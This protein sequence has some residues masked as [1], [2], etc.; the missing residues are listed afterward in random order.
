[1]KTVLTLLTLLVCITSH[2]SHAAQPKPYSEVRLD[3]DGDGRDDLV[4][5]RRTGRISFQLEVFYTGGRTA[6][7]Y[8]KLV[9]QELPNPADDHHEVTIV[10][11]SATSFRI[12]DLFDGGHHMSGSDEIVVEAL[13][14]S[15]RVQSAEYYIGHHGGD[16]SD[17]FIE[18]YDFVKGTAFVSSHDGVLDDQGNEA[19]PYH[20]KSVELSPSCHPELREWKPLDVPACAKV[21]L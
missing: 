12:T 2:T 3:L 13:N 1:M 4:R 9:P 16:Q 17:A 20:E 21:Q 7:T 10:K 6:E 18:K 5:I 19:E 8:D 14:G 11:L 15:L